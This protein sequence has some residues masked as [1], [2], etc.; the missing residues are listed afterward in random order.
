MTLQEDNKNKLAMSI[1]LVSET[2]F[3]LDAMVGWVSSII[4]L[5]IGSMNIA[6][7]VGHAAAIGG[8]LVALCGGFF[9]MLK[10]R[11]GWLEAKAKRK[12]EEAKLE[13]L[14]DDDETLGV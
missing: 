2:L 4:L 6:E 1:K 7:T 3:G 12:Q 10:L 14:Q 5:A 13:D 9:S 11:E 8:T